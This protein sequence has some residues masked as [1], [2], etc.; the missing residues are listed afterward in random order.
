[1]TYV[2]P[3]STI[4]HAATVRPAGYLEAVLAAGTVS[5]EGDAQIVTLTEQAYAELLARYSGKTLQEAFLDK[6]GPAP[7]GRGPG[8]EL[9][10]LLSKFGINHTPTC[11]CREMARKMDLW[12]PDECSKP[13]RI[14]EVLAA[15]R[16]EAKKRGL[17]F[18]DAAG[19]LLIKRAIRNARAKQE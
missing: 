15:M 6:R 11:P 10:K 2:F 16:T 12:G 13:E 14:E 3:I 9:S 8:T 19:R 7:F 18:L 1:M 17:P 4:R 5:G